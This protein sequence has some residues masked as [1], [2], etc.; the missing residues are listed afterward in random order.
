MMKMRKVSLHY[1][2]KK[3]FFVRRTNFPMKD[4]LKLKKGVFEQKPNF[5]KKLFFVRLMYFL[6]KGVFEQKPNFLKKLFFVHL[7]YY[8]MKGELKQLK[9]VFWLR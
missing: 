2:L 7:M 5:P 3:V 8:L 4:G 9:K 1:C 6:K